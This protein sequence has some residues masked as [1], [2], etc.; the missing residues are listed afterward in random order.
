MCQQLIKYQHVIAERVG[1]KPRQF[2]RGKLVRATGFPNSYLPV[3]NRRL[4][5][6]ESY[7]D[8]LF[9]TCW[10]Q[11]RRFGPP[12]LR[13]CRAEEKPVGVS[14]PAAS[15]R[16]CDCLPVI[17]SAMSRHTARRMKR[18]FPLRRQVA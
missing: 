2:V 15:M 4:C 1:F 12:E 11:L 6:A 18:L 10:G 9:S 8:V 5:Q 7:P 17:D 3:P 14:R 16:S 13:V